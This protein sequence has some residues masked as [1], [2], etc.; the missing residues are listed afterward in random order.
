MWVLINH[1]CMQLSDR[2]VSSELFLLEARRVWTLAKPQIAEEAAF[3]INNNASLNWRRKWE[4][5][6]QAEERKACK[7]RSIPVSRG[8][9]LHFTLMAFQ[10][11]P[12]LCPSSNSPRLLPHVAQT[13]TCICANVLAHLSIGRRD[14][15]RP[16]F[17]TM[18]RNTSSLR[19]TSSLFP[20]TDT[21]SF[22]KK[23]SVWR[24]DEVRV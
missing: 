21:F 17:L 6:S 9:F 1:F 12:A 16:D 22:K 23:V 8:N 20:R 13:W 11:A 3:D 7:K 15:S 5:L 2:F 14:T 18:P 4:K 10:E 24:P 19:H